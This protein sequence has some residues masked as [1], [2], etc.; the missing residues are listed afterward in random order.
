MLRPENGKSRLRRSL[1][2]CTLDFMV[3]SFKFVGSNSFSLGCNQVFSL[4]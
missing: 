4:E 1:D 3:Q 2:A